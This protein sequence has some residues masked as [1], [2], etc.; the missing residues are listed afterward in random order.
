MAINELIYCVQ[1]LI[2]DILFRVH[3][4][5]SAIVSMARPTCLSYFV[6]LRAVSDIHGLL[7]TANM[8]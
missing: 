7:R 6:D 4:D 1:T 5:A 3:H 8:F 2:L